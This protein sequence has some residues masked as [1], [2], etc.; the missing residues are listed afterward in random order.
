MNEK[1]YQMIHNGDCISRSALLEHSRIETKP[2]YDHPYGNSVVD[3]DDIENAPGLEVVLLGKYEQTKWERD[4]AI[5]Q[6]ESYGLSLGE[7]AEVTKVRHGRWIAN[8][9]CSECR[10]SIMG[11]AIQNRYL[12]CPHCNAMMDGTFGR[13]EYEK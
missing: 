8:N 4:V 2:T 11:Y 5:A 13:E 1:Q 10:K 12:Y 9:I 6:L 7:K 3:V